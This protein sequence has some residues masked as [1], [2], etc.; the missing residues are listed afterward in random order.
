[1]EDRLPFDIFSAVD[2][3]SRTYLPE[4]TMIT[5]TFALVTMTLCLLVASAS[6]A[7]AMSYGF[8]WGKG[9]IGA[10]HAWIIMN[11][12]ELRSEAAKQAA[13]LACT[14]M[15]KVPFSGNACSRAIDRMGQRPFGGRTNRGAFAE[16]SVYLRTY[17]GFWGRW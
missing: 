12:V 15:I 9:R 13:S 7:H 4:R 1:M 16:V 8:D 5:R 11:E 6:N 3:N 14:R 2:R 17:I 10:P